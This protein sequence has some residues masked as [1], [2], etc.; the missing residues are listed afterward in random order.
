LKLVSSKLNALFGNE[1]GLSFKNFNIWLKISFLTTKSLWVISGFKV[2]LFWLFLLSD[3]VNNSSERLKSIKG[4]SDHD[5]LPINQLID[6]K[7]SN[8][9]NLIWHFYLFNWFKWIY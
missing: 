3:F 6:L 1:F 8:K 4:L 9:K 7:I 5:T 2:I